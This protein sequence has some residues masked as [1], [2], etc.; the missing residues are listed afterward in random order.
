[1]RGSRTLKRTTMNVDTELVAR[2]GEILGTR[3]TTQTVHQ[4]LEAVVRRDALRSLAGRRFAGMDLRTLEDLRR[5][6]LPQD[7]GDGP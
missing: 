5:G 1:M 7:G 4:A 2:A 3:G 6:R